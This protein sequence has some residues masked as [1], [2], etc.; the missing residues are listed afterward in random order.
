MPKSRRSS[1]NEEI[2]MS[3]PKTTHSVNEKSLTNGTEQSTLH[4][5]EKRRRSESHL[6]A[7]HG[8]IAT[9]E[10]QTS[11][12]LAQVPLPTPTSTERN[13]AN[14]FY[15][16]SHLHRKVGL[17]HII[18]LLVLAAY[19]FLG[20]V[21]FYYLETPYERTL[22]A[23]RK[24]KLNNRLEQLADHI[25]TLSENETVE[26]LAEQI[27][28]AYVEMLD[29]EGT[30]KW[31]IFYRSS[32]P[33]NNYKWTYA[34]S[35]FF[36]MN[37]YTTTGYGSIA[38]ETLAGQWFVIIYGFI[39]VPV[40]LVVVRDLGQWLLLAIT[41]LY[42]KV[43]L[44]YR[45]WR[46]QNSEK[47]NEIIHLPIIISVLIMIAAILACAEFVYYLDAFS[48]P[49]G[50]GMDWFHTLY[51]SYMSFTTIGLGDVMPNNATFAPIVS[52]LFFLGLPILKVVN[53]MTYL[54]VENGSF[55]ILTVIEN[56]LDNY[57]SND[58]LP[59]QG[60]VE[61]GTTGETDKDHENKDEIH[62]DWVNNITIHSI[63]TF[64]RSN[65]DVYGGGF[66]KVNLRAAD[67]LPQ[68]SQ[69]TV[70]S[71]KSNR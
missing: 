22:I 46:G 15:W 48:G 37:V 63:A 25:D 36:A 45:R 21:V 5:Y 56:R 2:Q 57:W 60:G 17:S 13:F 53:R 55:G 71:R 23:E 14:S 39:F 40:T 64:M 26:E 58:R 27:K 11:K 34:S 41:K 8:A 1:D 16:L 68:D 66:G 19:T 42:A 70:R 9:I 32:D 30:Y 6:H 59:A 43:L 52:I 47:K 7:N 20:A 61:S 4:N 10:R 24:V 51:F 54:T 69:D 49:P 28:A 18:L 33:E 65:S 44:R 31:S 12:A 29:V 35:F 67:V 38:P 3:I 62:P 50:T